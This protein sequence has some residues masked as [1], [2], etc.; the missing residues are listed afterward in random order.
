M[1]NTISKANWL[2]QE[3]MRV[4]CKNNKGHIAPSL[5]C[6][7]ILVVLYYEPEF[8]NDTVILS[9]AHGCYSL[10]AIEADL[11][12]ISK[13]DWENFNL[14]GTYEGL[15]SLGHGMPIAVGLAYGR[16][17]QGKP[18]HIYCIVGDGE[19][20]EG[21]MW[22][23]LS[24][25]CHHKLNNITVIIDNNHLQ[26]LDRI[27][28]VLWHNLRRRITGFGFDPCAVDGHNHNKLLTVLAYRP[29]V[30]IAN[31]IKGKGYPAIEGKPEFHHRI[32]TE[33]ERKW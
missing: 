31:T 25:L 6:L 14:K 21:S 9:K 28:N 17:L 4:A 27:E 18:G 1:T 2:R 3:V 16:A 26:A 20:Q 23:A 19:M 10:Y 8:K 30:I 32:P 29:Q 12:I 24:F 5:S 22:E 7:D 13:E 11:G 15:G 33:E